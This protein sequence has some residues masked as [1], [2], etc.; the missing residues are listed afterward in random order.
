MWAGAAP[1][2][3]VLYA[4]KNVTPAAIIFYDMH[5][6]VVVPNFFFAPTKKSLAPHP[7]IVAS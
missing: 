4:Y 6:K 2:K 3:F 1:S 5:S 7:Q